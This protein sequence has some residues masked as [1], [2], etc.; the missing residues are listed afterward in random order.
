[1]AATLAAIR[2]PAG[3]ATQLLRRTVVSLQ[4][5]RVSAVLSSQTKLSIWSNRN[6]STNGTKPLD[7]S[8][9]F[10]PIPTPF[11]KDENISYEHLENNIKRWSEIP[12]KGKVYFKVFHVFNI[13]VPMI[14]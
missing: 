8:G 3:C 6:M 7:I 10:P 4:S 5:H 2:A 14:V 12:F 9:I 1:M 13:L 11:D